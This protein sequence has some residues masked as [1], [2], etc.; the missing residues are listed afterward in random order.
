MCLEAFSKLKH[1]I[2]LQHIFTRH[3]FQEPRSDNTMKVI[4]DGF[5]DVWLLDD[6]LR[7]R[8]RLGSAYST[9]ASMMAAR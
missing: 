1:L 9:T 4:M 7:W 3:P 6:R 5:I 2:M 8:R